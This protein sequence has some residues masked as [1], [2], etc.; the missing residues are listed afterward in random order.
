MATLAGAAGEEVVLEAPPIDLRLEAQV[1][2]FSLALQEQSEIVL[3]VEQEQE[4]VVAL[5]MFAPK[6]AVVVP[7]IHHTQ[8]AHPTVLDA[9][10]EQQA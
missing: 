8:S 3:Q 1:V 2:P 5:E 4:E 7:Q 10:R 6:V 9:A